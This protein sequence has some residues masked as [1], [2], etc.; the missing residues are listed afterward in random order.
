MSAARRDEQRDDSPALTTALDLLSR[1]HWP[2]AIYLAGLEYTDEKGETAITTGKEPIG[3]EW[4]KKRPTPAMLRAKF[5]ANPGA[6][7]GLRVGPEAGCIDIENDTGAEGDATLLEMMGGEVLESMGWLA[8]R[9]GHTLAQ[10]DHRL[11]KY[12]KSIIKI[13]GLEIRIGTVDLA[14]PKQMQSVCPP[15]PK[16][17]G[18]PR[19]WNGC[20][21]IATLPESFFAYLDAAFPPVPKNTQPAT[22]PIYTPKPG[23][24]TAEDRARAY[25]AKV[26]PAVSGQK[27]HDKAIYAAVKV[28]PGFD[29]PPDR[30]YAILG[31]W[32]RECVPPWSEKELQH[33]ISEAY[34]VEPRR[35]W[36]L[37]DNRNEF[38]HAKE[39]NKAKEGP[40]VNSLPSLIS[41]NP[42]DEDERPA[43]VRKWPDPP[44]NRIFHGPAG[45][46]ALAVEPHTEGDPIGILGQLLVA[47]GCM[48]GRRIYFQVSETKHYANMFICTAGRSGASRKGTAWDIVQTV[49]TRCDEDFANERRKSGLTSGEGLIYAVRDE[50]TKKTPIRKDGKIIGYDDEIIDAGIADKRLLVVE[51]E[52]GRTLKAMGREGNTLSSILRH[53][54][55]SGSLDSL[56]KG[57][58]NRATDAHV[59]MVA[60]VTGDEVSKLL[61]SIDAANGF[62]NRFLWLSVQSTKCLPRGAPIPPG[63]MARP[64]AAMVDAARKFRGV[65]HTMVRDPLAEEYWDEVYRQLASE[66][67]GLIGSILARGQPITMRLAM[68]YALIDGD[69]YIRVHH[70]E[71]AYALWQYADQS[72]TYIFSDAMGDRDAD[73]LLSTLRSTPEGLTRTVISTIVF[74]GHKTREDLDRVLGRLVECN[75]IQSVKIP[76][77]GAPRTVWRAVPR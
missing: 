16:A 43:L 74:R 68:I 31:E 19:E 6:G 12:G 52:F 9:G 30:A 8:N 60:H 67:P 29:L 27:G 72:A 26:E 54:W 50:V 51:S 5:A 32:S 49:M 35:G 58:Q 46:L 70:I 40:A 61:T 11:V 28:G 20:E 71:A 57:N 21:D 48:I 69:E 53:A 45:D 23:Q 18:T 64:I 38:G 75:L 37:E 56:T 17:D 2:L 22:I 63:A 15:T 3:R 41:Q 14:K 25:I 73:L 47:F 76:T 4:G 10:F 39:A 77:D 42:S 66:R 55:D 65:I 1:G 44:K 24:W 62:A 59:S 13:G 34:K 7:L 33:K 36:L